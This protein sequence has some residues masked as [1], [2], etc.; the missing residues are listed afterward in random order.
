MDEDTHLY[1]PRPSTADMNND[2]AANNKRP[3]S[4]S[5]DLPPPKVAKTMPV[6]QGLQINYLHRM[7]NENLPLCNTEDSLPSILRLVGEYEGVIQRHESIAGNLGACPLGPI[8]LKRFER[9]FDGPPHILKS[10]GKEA[11]VTWLDVVDF[12]RNKPE[13][14]NLEKMRNG[15]RVCQFY[16]KQCRVEISEE[17]FVLI[18][19]GMPQKLIPPQPIVEDEEKELGAIQILEKN[20]SQ[21]VQL[22][23]QRKL[24]KTSEPTHITDTYLVS[25]RARQLN[26]KLG[27]RKNAILRRRETDTEPTASEPRR[28]TLGSRSSPTSPVETNGFSKQ[29][30]YSMDDQS[31]SPPSGFTAVNMR[32]S[33]DDTREPDP[34]L[35]RLYAEAN[36]GNVTIV[37]GRSIKGASPTL[38]Y[39]LM[40]KFFSPTDREAN[41]DAELRRSSSNATRLDLNSS[42]MR[43]TPKARQRSSSELE[44]M[45]YSRGKDVSAVAIPSTPVDL[46]PNLKQIIRDLDD[47]GPFKAEMVSRM[48]IMDRGTRVIPPCDRCRRL[49]MDCLKNLTACLGCTK[50]H[51]KCSWKDVRIEE[52]QRTAKTV[53]KTVESIEQPMPLEAKKDVEMQEILTAPLPTAPEPSPMVEIQS[54]PPSHAESVA[55]AEKPIPVDVPA[56]APEQATEPEESTSE[57]VDDD[58][59]RFDVRP[60][61]VAQPQSNGRGQYTPFSYYPQVKDSIENDENDEGDRLQALAA[62][63]YRSASQSVR[64]QTQEG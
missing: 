61:P 9:L 22:A 31:Q 14:F 46:M 38:R 32:Q 48:E 28:H 55:E 3:R 27:N 42:Y 2:Y 51:A 24:E 11:N 5:D 16:T 23:D 58:K 64:P 35:E 43:E 17:D 47:G 13:Q 20:L 7:H 54:Q 40:K 33:M 8:L 21:I 4:P 59:P 6:Q 30:H 10:H 45:S 56:D 26:H 15:V 1:A 63:V 50:K 60:P 18:A 37:N 52:L 62:Q 41:A 34:R 39:E 12:A 49:H 29:Q 19:S 53:N 44:L 36:T 25:G 57:K